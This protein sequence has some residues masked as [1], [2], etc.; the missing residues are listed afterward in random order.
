MNDKAQ[1]W[2]LL[3]L[4][5]ALLCLPVIFTNYAPLVDY[6]NHLARAYILHFYESVPAYRAEYRVALEPLPNLALDLIV[7]FT[8]GVFGLL[9]AGKIFLVLTVLVFVAGCHRLG[10][11]IQGTPTW[12]AVP[13]CFL[14]YN[15]T[16]LY[17]FVN[18]VFGIGLFCVTLSYW[19]EWRRELT[20]GRFLLLTLLVVCSYLA[21]LSAYS[22]LG[23]AFVTVAAWDYF[24]HKE[25]LRKVVPALAPLV[26]PAALFVIFMR[27]SGRTGQVEWNTL[28]GKAVGL[29]S[30]VL[31]YNYA[32]DVCLLAALALASLA[33]ARAAGSLRVAWPT[34][35]AG[36]AFLLLYFLSPKVLFTSSGADARFILPCVLLCVLSLG[37]ALRG[38]AG[39]VLLL[40][41]LCV[42]CVRLGAIWKTWAGLDARIAAEAARL[43]GALPE[44]A[45]IYPVLVLPPERQREKL[46]RSFTHLPHYATVSRHAFVPTLFA[47]E[48]QQPLRF[49]ER[50]RFAEAAS[51]SS[52]EWRQLSTRWLSYLDDYDYLWAYGADEPLRKIIEGRCTKVYD[53]DGFSLWRVN[54]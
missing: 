53:E 18:Y 51:Y 32:L 15:S 10:R 25:P 28:A 36:A 1:Y 4:A 24:A 14:V 34:F 9:T 45:R 11:A 13:C 48:G 54:R 26:F 8:L 49:R 6:P 39:K 16:F 22:F 37:V 47:L 35:T 40:A 38:R 30:P 43:G 5:A 31:T 33:L 44:G 19:L 3:C 23:A 21:H 12:L 52:E 29:L 20:A 46:E 50:P 7:P 2:C 17:G 41:I 42:A 27:G